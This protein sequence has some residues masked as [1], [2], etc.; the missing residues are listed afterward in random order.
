M[1]ITIIY[2]G[3]C[4]VKYSA[5]AS[6]DLTLPISI[7]SVQKAE[8]I[9]LPVEHVIASN[10]RGAPLIISI[11]IRIGMEKVPVF[12]LRVNSGTLKNMLGFHWF[13]KQ[14]ISSDLRAD[15]SEGNIWT[16]F[17][18]NVDICWSTKKPACSAG[19]VTSPR[20]YNSSC[21]PNS[22]P[23]TL[24]LKQARINI[25]IFF[26]GGDVWLVFVLLLFFSLFF[27]LF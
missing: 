3:K 14:D 12:P 19:K 25:W 1:T 18:A 20:Q 22:G 13:V 6:C 10:N 4:G 24:E 9:S 17:P 16:C 11:K 2:I 5:Q 27:G 23:S 8:S 7:M 21:P 15:T 26:G